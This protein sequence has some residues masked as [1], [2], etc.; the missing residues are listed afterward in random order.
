MES[1]QQVFAD[2]VIALKSV[3][4]PTLGNPRIPHL[5][6]IFILCEVGAELLQFACLQVTQ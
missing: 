3:D 2:F 6:P 4:L 5:K 1:F